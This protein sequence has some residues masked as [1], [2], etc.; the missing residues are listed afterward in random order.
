MRCEYFLSS[1]FCVLSID[2]L[3]IESR[4]LSCEC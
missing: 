3:S 1:E 4:I 2:F